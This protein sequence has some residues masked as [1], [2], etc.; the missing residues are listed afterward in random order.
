MRSLPFLTTAIAL[1][2]AFPEII[3]WLPDR[4]LN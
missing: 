2:V 4:M 3:T 1:F